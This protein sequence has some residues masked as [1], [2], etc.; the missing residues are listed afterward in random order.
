[1]KLTIVQP[2]NPL[3]IMEMNPYTLDMQEV[4]IDDVRLTPA[5]ED[6]FFERATIENLRELCYML[7]HK[8]EENKN[9]R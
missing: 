1:M 2:I 6:E 3:M 7:K 4:Y 8:M 5:L 9:E